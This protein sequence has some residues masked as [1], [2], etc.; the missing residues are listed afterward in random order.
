[1]ITI[2]TGRLIR[3]VTWNQKVLSRIPLNKTRDY[4]LLPD[5]VRYY[6]I[7][8]FSAAIMFSAFIFTTP[9]DVLSGLRQIMVKPGV[10]V[11][12]YMAVA[13]IGTAFFNSGFLMLVCILII[14]VNKILMEG[15]VIAAIF[16]VG[17]FALFGK[18]PLNIWPIIAGV[19]LYARFRRERFSKV[20]LIALFGT[21]LGPMVSQIAFGFGLTSPYALILAIVIGITVG[22]CLPPMANQFVLFHQ[23]FN[24][25]NIG[26]TCGIAGM[27]VMSIF[28]AF[29]YEIDNSALI[30]SQGN[31]S[32]LSV[33]L[34]VL[35]CLLLLTGLFFS[36]NHLRGMRRLFQQSGR[37]VSDFVSSHGFGPALINMALL[38]LISTGY[39]LLVR[40]EL[41]GPTIGGI[42]TIVGFGAFG[43]HVLNVLPL[44]GGVYLAT[45]LKLWETSSTGALLAALFGTT[46]A[47]I[48]GA[49][50][51][52]Y[53]IAAGFIHMSVV[54]NVGYLHGGMNLYNNGFAGG[55]VAAILVPVFDTLKN[56]LNG[57]KPGDVKKKASEDGTG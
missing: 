41:N 53:G 8:F 2:I 47:P 50:G 28:R 40:G 57:K 23:G 36:K 13:D 6:V 25:Y 52:V 9:A 43:K 12:D 19:W 20:I 34:L 4:Y 55:F 15:P 7:T 54:M 16:T 18:T 56:R 33:Y 49:Y 30:I 10:L 44:L 48:A 1:M 3:L 37:L 29:S 39:V 26:F 35:F 24:L 21:A 38:G 32:V 31:N 14:K 27:A 22:F 11:T 42:F 17:G 5:N 45:L 46:L 51:W